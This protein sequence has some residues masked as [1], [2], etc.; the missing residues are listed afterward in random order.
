MAFAC[1]SFDKHGAGARWKRLDE[2]LDRRRVPWRFLHGE[3]WLE[4]ARVPNAR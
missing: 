1:I 3:P 4:V 2:A